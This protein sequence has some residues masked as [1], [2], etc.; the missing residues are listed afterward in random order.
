[1]TSA[2]QATFS[3]FRIIKGRKVA[4]IH[5]EVPIEAANSALDVLGGVPNPESEVWVAVA[6]LDPKASAPQFQ[7][8]DKPRRRWDEMKPTEQAGIACQDKAFWQ[9]LEILSGWEV[10]SIDSA[11]NAAGE[12]RNVLAITSRKAL[13]KVP[14][15]AGSWQRLYADFLTWSGRTPEAR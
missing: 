5:L 11:E 15:L 2:F 1:M 10:G 6:R 13:D 9:F 3:D 8:A 12:M 4:Q 14:A 7:Q